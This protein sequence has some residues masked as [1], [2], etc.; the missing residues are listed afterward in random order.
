MARKGGISLQR[1]AEEK[2]PKVILSIHALSSQEAQRVALCTRADMCNKVYT[3]AA[4]QQS[5]DVRVDYAFFVPE[6][7]EIRLQ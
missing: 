4:E 6:N 2:I 5:V 1:A 3:I 7:Q